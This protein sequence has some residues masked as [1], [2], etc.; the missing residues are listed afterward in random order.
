MSICTHNTIQ[1]SRFDSTVHKDGKFYRISRFQ[2]VLCGEYTH[3][4]Q[5]EVEINGFSWWGHSLISTP[6]PI[7][8]WG[9][10]PTTER[11]RW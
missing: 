8:E 4:E 9:N 1:P 2:C 6:V 3:Q 10:Q 11:V 5:T 7:P